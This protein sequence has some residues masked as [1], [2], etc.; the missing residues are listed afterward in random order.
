LHQLLK[1]TD[2]IYYDV[3][4]GNAVKKWI[5]GV[6][7]T[8]RQISSNSFLKAFA[9]SLMWL[10]RVKASNIVKHNYWDCIEKAKLPLEHKAAYISLI[11]DYERMP[12]VLSHNDL[13]ADN[14]IYT[15]SK[16]VVFIDYEWARMNNKYWDVANFIR[17]V[18]LPLREI[19]IL[20]KL[21]KFNN[22]HQLLTFVYLTTNYAYQWT[23]N[24]P[25]TPI[26]KR[27]R[28]LTFK[29]LK[30]YYQFVSN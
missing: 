22:L 26:M 6:N 13:S 4:N 29:K 14:L 9:E 23:F 17:E 11:K 7:P 27:Y 25:F 21:L 2:F 15:P 19:K 16:K 28:Q 3:S 1:L 30:R 24:M 5:S 10:H 12:L 8:K 18:N 20:C